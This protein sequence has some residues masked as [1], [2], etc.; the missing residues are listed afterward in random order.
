MNRSAMNDVP[1]ARQ[2][3]TDRRTSSEKNQIKIKGALCASSAFYEVRKPVLRRRCSVRPFYLGG[4]NGESAGKDLE[5]PKEGLEN[6][7]LHERHFFCMN[8]GEGH[9]KARARV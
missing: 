1:V 7:I 5:Q 2:S 6:G 9:Y 8:G 4:E 3:R